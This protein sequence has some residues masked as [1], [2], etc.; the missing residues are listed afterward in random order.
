MTR[1]NPLD[2]DYS[3]KVQ[4][5]YN[6]MVRVAKEGHS[7]VATGGFHIRYNAEEDPNEVYAEITVS[8]SFGPNCGYLGVD[9]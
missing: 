7:Y 9:I 4:S 8:P 6:T 5:I 2:Q 3:D 1:S